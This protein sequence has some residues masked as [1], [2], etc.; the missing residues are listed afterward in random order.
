M[1]PHA[2]AGVVQTISVVAVISNGAVIAFSSQFV[3]RAVYDYDKGSLTGYV[4]TIYPIFKNV[5]DS[6]IEC[7]FVGCH[8]CA[9]HPNRL[10]STQFASRSRAPRARSSTKC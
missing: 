1:P 8:R 6:N 2:V 10:A 9:A 3:D 5:T 7:Q 4:N